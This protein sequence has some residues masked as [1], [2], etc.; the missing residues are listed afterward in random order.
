MDVV[1][2]LYAKNKFGGSGGGNP[3]RVQVIEADFSLPTGSIDGASVNPD[4]LAAALASNNAHAILNV[5]ASVLGFGVLSFPLIS[6]DDH[7]T[8]A[9][10]EVAADSALGLN[11]IWDYTTSNAQHDWSLVQ[12]YMLSLPGGSYPTATID[13]ITEYAAMFPT[14]LTIYWHPMPSNTVGQAKVGQA[15]V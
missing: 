7:F 1:D 6:L 10:A 15:Q 9:S 2:I 4:V 11:A 12:A 3:N 5:D 8:V 13:D 14:T